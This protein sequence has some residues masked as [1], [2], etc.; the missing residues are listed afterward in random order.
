MSTLIK[1]RISLSLQII[2]GFIDLDTNY[3]AEVVGTSVGHYLDG[4]GPKVSSV[5]VL[6]PP[7]SD[8]DVYTE[9]ADEV[10]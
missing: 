2:D 9:V 1:V 5:V 4:M 6:G 8:N 3:Y 7:V 10:V